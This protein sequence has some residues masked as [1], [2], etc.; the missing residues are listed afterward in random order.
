MESLFDDGEFYVC[1][2]CKGTGVVFDDEID[3]SR[4]CSCQAGGEVAVEDEGIDAPGLWGQARAAHDAAVKRVDEAADP[5]WKDDALE[6]IRQVCL[7]T[8]DFIVDDVWATGLR[9]TRE[10][11]ALGPQMTRA[12][13][14][15]YCVKTDR[16]R[17]SVRSHLSGKPVWMSLIFR[18]ADGETQAI[19]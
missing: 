17:P 1:P 19:D 13:V 3:G 7:T 6:A 14:H 11:R 12:R 10:D 8:V 16:V 4:T 15:G 5:F 2:I 9:S 18:Q